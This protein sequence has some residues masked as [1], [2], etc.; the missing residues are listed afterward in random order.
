MN[1]EPL[2]PL[3]SPAEPPTVYL[4]GCGVVGQAIIHAHL[5]AGCSV[6]ACDLDRQRL[7][8]FAHR[9]PERFAGAVV[10]V[11]EPLGG[12]LPRVQIRLPPN[13]PRP[14][15]NSD[16][17]DAALGPQPP[18]L[19]IESIY[20][21]REAKRQLLGQLQR[22][23]G[24]Q[25]VVCSN[26][27]TLPI[28]GL[29]EQMSH[30]QQGC[31]MH[32]FMPVEQRDLV[33]IV[34][35][36]T[37]SASTIRAATA[38]ARRIGKAALAV[39]DLPGFVVNRMLSP[40]INESL[41][42]L[43]L[44]ATAEQLE[45]V[46]KDFGMPISPLELIDWIG[47]R[48]AFDAGRVYWQAFPKRLDPAPLLPALVKAKLPGRSGGKG[49]YEYFDA[50]A[51][52]GEAAEQGA[53]VGQQRRSGALC[54]EAAELVQRYTRESRSWS[55]QELRWQLFLPMLIEADLILQAGGVATTGE[56]ET[57]MRGG[58]GFAAPGG[59]FAAFERCGL[60]QL[61]EEL[62]RRGTQPSFSA[63]QDLLKRLDRGKLRDREE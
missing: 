22:W 42:L 49:F 51:E 23:L 15:P 34:V 21:N 24:T 56:I 60:G 35:P 16:A 18:P 61:A 53:A 63:A 25:A 48:T 14:N 20:E 13:S 39:A 62:R 1:L 36:A 3:P 43:C 2:L 41:R 47:P 45:R 9:L 44:G 33:E 37:A 17:A 8:S 54:P 50:A 4:I 27:S 5:A 59:F 10:T 26:T 46:V 12:E 57:A 58:L 55:E 40:Y 19:A 31:G 52:Q 11:A 28:A 6:Q 30:P 38:H 32:F 29:V 7:E